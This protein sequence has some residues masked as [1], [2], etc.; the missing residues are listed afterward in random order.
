MAAPAEAFS[1]KPI[2]Y[3]TAV[4]HTKSDTVSLGAQANAVYVGTGGTVT[5]L[6]ADA[7]TVQFTNVANGTILPIRLVRV[8]STGTS[9]SDFVALF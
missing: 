8:N 1:P 4:A 9:A 5:V 7:T 2:T 3:L 6:L